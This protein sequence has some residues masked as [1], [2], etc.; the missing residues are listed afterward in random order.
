M[1]RDAVAISNGDVHMFFVDYS[2]IYFMY[3][4]DALSGINA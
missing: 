3:I 1:R 4:F 2:P